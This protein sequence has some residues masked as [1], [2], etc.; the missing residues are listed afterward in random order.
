MND[1]SS[2]LATA[3]IAER[4]MAEDTFFVAHYRF[5]ATPL[6]Y[7]SITV[8]L[9][10]LLQVVDPMAALDVVIALYCLALPLT[11]LWVL[12]LTAPDNQLFGLAGAVLMFNWAFWLGE[13]NFL[14]GQPLLLAG[15]ALFV[16]LKR[17]RSMRFLLFCGC[18]V[19]IYFS[20]LFALVGL[21]T[22]VGCWLLRDLVIRIRK[23][24]AERLVPAHHAAGVICGLL[25]AGAAHL[26]LFGHGTAANRGRIVFDFRPYRLAQLA[27]LPL[28]TA[29]WGGRAVAALFLVGL[30][31]AVLG[32]LVWGWRR[33][34]QARAGTVYPGLLWP[35]LGLLGLAYL[36]P[37]GVE[38]EFGFEDIGQR[39]TLVG[40]LLALGSVRLQGGRLQRVAIAAVLAAG[41]LI[42]TMD[43]LI[44]GRR[45][46]AAA[47][48][49]SAL[50][51]QLPRHSRVLPLFDMEAPDRL[52]LLLHRFG[53]YAVVERHAYGP[54]VF[55]RTG[56]QPLR[57][58]VWGD[59]RP[60]ARLEVSPA[61]W[62]FYDHLLVQ[63]DRAVPRVASLA[64][65]AEL[66]GRAGDFR[67]YRVRR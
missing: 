63:S 26:V 7:W 27:E 41:A 24:A 61:E 37:A 20:H 15:F 22:A 3:V 28:Q 35:A 59:Y 56:Q 38:E 40:L 30:A 55:A 54:H 25:L 6:P 33:G 32:P 49:V 64:E 67:L 23:H 14:I 47:R 45:H 8:L 2:H 10:A 50:L 51:L 4:L 66:V 34:E 13:L 12:R 17:W 58:R 5:E 29:A 11:W 60:V 62:Q 44:V 48:Q 46:D 1:A 53:N 52:D 57:H 31:A 42:K 43:L 9:A 21:V 39:F 65:R 36:G 19:A 18:A 16:G